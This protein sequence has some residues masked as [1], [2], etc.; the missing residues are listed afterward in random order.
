MIENVLT[1]SHVLLQRKSVKNPMFSGENYYFSNCNTV[2]K[3]DF[4]TIERVF[5]RRMYIPGK[6]IFC[7]FKNH[8]NQNV[9]LAK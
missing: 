7:K 8:L 4:L 5:V 3:T 6:I 2:M 9:V 1:I